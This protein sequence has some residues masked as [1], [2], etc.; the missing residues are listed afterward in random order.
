MAR[1]AARIDANQPAIV[2]A[3]RSVGATVHSLAAVGAGCPDLLVGYHGT[4]VL[5]EIKDGAKFPC[6]RV[7]TPLEKAWHEMWR[8]SVQ[9]VESVDEALS[10]IG[11]DPEER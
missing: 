7:L 10:A 5:F 2:R 6:E 4:N 9:V 11:V 8:G 1:R 3:L